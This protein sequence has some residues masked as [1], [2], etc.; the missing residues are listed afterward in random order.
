MKKD[1]WI[2]ITFIIVPLSILVL[3]INISKSDIISNNKSTVN[4]IKTIDTTTVQQDI[5]AKAETRGFKKGI[6]QHCLN[7]PW[8]EF[9][10]KKYYSFI[11]TLKPGIKL[12]RAEMDNMMLEV[13]VQNGYI[14]IQSSNFI[15]Y[16]QTQQVIKEMDAWLM[17]CEPTSVEG[18]IASSKIYNFNNYDVTLMN[19]N[20]GIH[21]MI[22]RNNG[23]PA[24]ENKA[25]ID[26][27]LEKLYSNEYFSIKFPTSW[28]VIKDDNKV[29]NGTSISVQIM[30]KESND[31]DFRPN[32]NIIVSGKKRLESAETLADITISQNRQA[33]SCY[34]LL[35]KDNNIT[36]SHC[37]G[38]RIEQ[39]FRIQ[40]YKLRNI[41]YIIKN[42]DNTVYT[43]TATMDASKYSTQVH[44]LKQ[45]INSLIIK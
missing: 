25:T 18:D 36:L 32:I 8:N 29:T 41:Q 23:N 17:S 14:K 37:Q 35:C 1:Y 11:E 44:I 30:E 3:I 6:I 27:P 42:L 19:E 39:Q 31:Y 43:I 15:L 12:Y 4:N 38:C 5:L 20:I 45:I 21:Y 10:D 9:K 28:Q 33:I 24:I 22:I 34:Q 2:G 26:I 16:N 13:Y 40:N 7:T